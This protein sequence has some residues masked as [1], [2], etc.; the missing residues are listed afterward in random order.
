MKRALFRISLIIGPLAIAL[1][2]S[3]IGPASAQELGAA[4][5]AQERH[6]PRLMGLANVVGT[7]V[8]LTAEGQPALKV[9]TK[10]VGVGGIP[11]RLDGIPV[12]VEVTGEIF[13]L[14]GGGNVSTQLTT[15]SIWPA[16][17]PIG[18]STG[19]DTQ[20]LAGTIGARVLGGT[21]YYALSNNHVYANE[22]QA[23]IGTPE[24][25]PGLYDTNCSASGDQ[26]ATLSKFQTINFNCTCFIFCSCDSTQDNT[27]D[28][29]V[30][31]VLPAPAPATWWVGNATPTSLGGYGAPVAG[32]GAV[33]CL[34]EPVQKFGR[35]TLLTQGTVS[36][37]N[38]TVI[39]NYGNG[40]YAEFAHQI[41]V[42]A[43]HA[44]IKPGDSGSLLVTNGISSCSAAGNTP[45]GLLFAGNSNGSA[46]FANPITGTDSSGNPIGVLNRLSACSAA[47]GCVGSVNGSLSIDGQ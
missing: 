26:I 13:A 3:L 36:G 33:A 5:A 46:A 28:A 37:V 7:G 44:F 6:T 43:S 47:S 1:V 24:Y 41:Q 15:T 8:G 30:A 9:F 14:K 10:V 4:I 35:T 29:A 34:N 45:V 16:P 20:C 12:V 17:V 27:I 32:S 25:Q 19:I 21:T 42:S 38:V 11:D 2:A 18:V 39:V 23:A 40:Q 22:N 31:Q